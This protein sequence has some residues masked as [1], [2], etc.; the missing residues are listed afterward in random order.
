MGVMATAESGLRERGKRR[1]AE[2]I[3]DSALDLLREDP[4]QALTIERIAARAEV[5]PM[6]VYNLIG[7]RDQL[8]SAL[9]D[10]AMRGVDFDAITG[11]D[12]QER[13]RRIVAAVVQ[14][15][16]ADASVF[17]ALLAGWG[18]SGRLFQ[19]DPTDTLIACLR[20]AA[21]HGDIAA[22]VDLK[23]HGE[24]IATGLVG[25]IHQWSGGLLSDRAF[26]ARAR[27]VVDVAFASAR[28][29]EMR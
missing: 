12:A 24:V 23:V 9:A 22:G 5:A 19:H 13:A 4:E 27:A 8:F 21:E 18:V 20:Q 29:G 25:A 6:T 14:A 7:G 15:L 11:S 17:R 2:R 16:R 26:A 10:R 1:R 3:L 28:S